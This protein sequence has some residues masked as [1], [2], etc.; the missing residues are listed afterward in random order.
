MPDVYKVHLESHS[1]FYPC[2]AT[3]PQLTSDNLNEVTCHLCRKR[4]EWKA[5]P[6][7]QRRVAEASDWL[8][9]YHTPD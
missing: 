6:G 5:D 1:G 4:A 3:S 2:G 9:W 7:N 8:D